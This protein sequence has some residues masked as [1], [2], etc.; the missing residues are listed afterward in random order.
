MVI[1]P[2]GLDY[3]FEVKSQSQVNGVAVF[4]F[5]ILIL[6]S[7]G[8]AVWRARTEAHSSRAE[9]RG[10][11]GPRSFRSVGTIGDDGRGRYPG[12]QDRRVLG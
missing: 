10:R 12:A 5:V 9:R 1:K 8:A 6:I 2:S 11:V 7:S 4:I 3:K